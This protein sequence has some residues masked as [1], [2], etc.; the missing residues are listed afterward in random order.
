[1]PLVAGSVTIDSEGTAAGTGL[2][3]ALADAKLAA[4]A[5]DLPTDANALASV[6]AGIAADC[7]ATADAVVTYLL[8]NAAPV[9]DGV[10]GTL[11]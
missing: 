8:A 6:Y 3:R 5:G 4:F 7:T 1:M 2:A 9:V 10:T 11:T